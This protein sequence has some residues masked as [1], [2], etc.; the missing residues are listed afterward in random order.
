MASKQAMVSNQALIEA[1]MGL[2]AVAEIYKIQSILQ[3]NNAMDFDDIIVL[4][5]NMLETKDDV[6]E[7]TRAIQYV[8]IDE[9]QDLNYAQYK[10][11]T[12]LSAK[13]RNLFAVGDLTK[14]FIRSV[15]LTCN[16]FWT[17]N[18]TT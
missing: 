6:R 13:H 11:V 18:L 8:S 2:K 4:T 7:S 3:K 5:V 15:A 14:R 16:L 9:Y 10:L 17:L 12:L 1:K